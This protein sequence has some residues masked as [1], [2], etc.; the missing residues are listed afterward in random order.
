MQPS[1]VIAE[2]GLPWLT[3]LPRHLGVNKKLPLAVY[4]TDV[5]ATPTMFDFDP[6]ICFACWSGNHCP[7]SSAKD[8]TPKTRHDGRPSAVKQVFM[9]ISANGFG[10]GLGRRTTKRRR[11]A[12]PR[13]DG[14]SLNGDLIY[15]ASPTHPPLAPSTCC[16]GARFTSLRPSPVELAVKDRLSLSREKPRHRQA[17]LRAGLSST[18]MLCRGGDALL[19]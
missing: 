14:E 13:R 12:T 19:G 7:M 2:G 15:D 3:R 10:R 1:P 5:R 9:L 16:P 4:A 8:T 11:A 6:D 17:C 18:A